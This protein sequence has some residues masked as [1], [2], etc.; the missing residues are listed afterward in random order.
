[1]PLT[2]QQRRIVFATQQDGGGTLCLLHTLHRTPWAEENGVRSQLSNLV[3]TCALHSHDAEEL[4]EHLR[5]C[6][7]Q[8][9]RA[10]AYAEA[11]VSD[12]DAFK[13]PACPG[14]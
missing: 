3:T 9:R 2:D 4:V 1:M 14:Q 8:L 10:L 7:E 5:Y 13:E 11:M 6:R 12:A